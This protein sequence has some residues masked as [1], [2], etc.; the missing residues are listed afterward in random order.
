MYDRCDYSHK[1]ITS[2][3]SQMK[4]QLG[5]LEASVQGFDNHYGKGKYKLPQNYNE[6]QV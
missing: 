2:L 1:D 5:L 3:K 4:T 6:N